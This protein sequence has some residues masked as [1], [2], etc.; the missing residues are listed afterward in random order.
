MFYNAIIKQIF[1]FDYCSTINDWMLEN[2][3]V[4]QIVENKLFIHINYIP[5]DKNHQKKLKDLLE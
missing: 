3:T 4:A 1:G 5:E 2:L